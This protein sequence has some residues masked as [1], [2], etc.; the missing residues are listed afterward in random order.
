MESWFLASNEC[1]A[2]SVTEVAR[3]G[4]DHRHPGAIGGS[5]HLLVTHRASGLDSG[6]HSGRGRSFQ[7]IGK[8][9]EGIAGKHRIGSPLARLVD[10]DAHA[11]EPV[12][13]TTA[14]ASQRPIPRQDNGV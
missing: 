10:R 9:E 2:R 4:E 7:T 13:L 12:R 6:G 3:P 11:L 14:D 8:W 5:D 1:P